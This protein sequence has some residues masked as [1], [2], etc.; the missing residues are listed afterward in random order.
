[1]I[2]L[3]V[4]GLVMDTAVKEILCCNKKKSNMPLSDLLKN[5]LTVEDTLV[6]GKIVVDVLRANNCNTALSL[7]EDVEFSTIVLPQGALE[8]QTESPLSGTGTADDPITIDTSA[9][10]SSY[11]PFGQ[12]SQFVDF[13][14]NPWFSY[15]PSFTGAVTDDNT[16]RMISPLPLSAVLVRVH[17]WEN[18][19][20]SGDL[21]VAVTPA[22]SIIPVAGTSTSLN[23]DTSGGQAPIDGNV[24]YT[25]DSTLPAL[26]PISIRGF[27]SGGLNNPNMRW[28]VCGI[29]A[30]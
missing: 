29:V 2:G 26:T 24:V 23:V 1:M 5:N 20:L 28:Y 9:L 17:V 8:V 3:W 13:V 16:Y 15:G 18:L 30:N 12:S 25:F 21:T 6:G 19:V 7:L 27:I 11:V 4:D 22:L 10:P 14:S